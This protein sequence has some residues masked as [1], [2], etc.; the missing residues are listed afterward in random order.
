MYSAKTK[1]NLKLWLIHWTAQTKTIQSG[2]TKKENKKKKICN[3]FV[4]DGNV[5]F[6]KNIA[7]HLEIAFY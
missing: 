5:Q 7:S 6:N 1:V 4:E 3:N 2:G